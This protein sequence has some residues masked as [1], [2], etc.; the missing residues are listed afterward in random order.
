[1]YICPLPEVEVAVLFCDWANQRHIKIEDEV[2]RRI[3]EDTGCYAGLVGFFGTSLDNLD[4]TTLPSG[5]TLSVNLW[6]KHKDRVLKQLLDTDQFSRATASINYNSSLKQFVRQVIVPSDGPYALSDTNFNF[7]IPLADYGIL[8][9][10]QQGTLQ[11]WFCLTSPVLRQI[12][13][14]KCYSLRLRL[15]FKADYLKNPLDLIAF[16]VSNLCAE[17]LNERE[18]WNKTTKFP[19]EYTFQAEF[20]AI[21]REALREVPPTQTGPWTVLVEAKT[22]GNNCRADILIQNGNRILIEIKAHDKQYTSDLLNQHVGQVAAYAKAL[23]C[24]QVVLLNVASSTWVKS[25][26]YLQ[27]NQPS[28]TFQQA[29]NGVNVLLVQV[30]LSSDFSSHKWFNLGQ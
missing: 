4:E 28:T 7:I 19:S 29:S 17:N 23:C 11:D 2:V 14:E 10:Q 24:R 26:G 27:P 8:I 25:G 15:P 30:E 22:M 16:M 1:V 6:M 5:S 20:Y 3:I 18:C 21:L 12:L 13:L 9:K